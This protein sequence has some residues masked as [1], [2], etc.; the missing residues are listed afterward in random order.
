M[1]VTVALA[2]ELVSLLA[3]PKCKGP[4]AYGA[5]GF[6]CDACRLLF[7]VEDGI[8]N[9][10]LTDALHTGPLQTGPLQTAAS[11]LD[12]PAQPPSRGPTQGSS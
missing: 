1:E 12:A 8:P 9:F 3:C 7:K 6:T 2:P 10:L 4:L 11:G 5:E